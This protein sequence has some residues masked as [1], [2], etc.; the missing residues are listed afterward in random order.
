MKVA[1]LCLFSS[2]QPE[3]YRTDMCFPEFLY[4]PN[5]VFRVVYKVL[6]KCMM[7]CECYGFALA[8]SLIRVWY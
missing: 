8:P 4:C 6:C 5:S 1:H 3:F 2:I 7:Q